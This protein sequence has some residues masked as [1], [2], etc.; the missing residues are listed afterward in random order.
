M[1][2]ARQ[3]VTSCQIQKYENDKK[4]IEPLP[5]RSGACNADINGNYWW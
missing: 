2:L 4:T 1:P 3:W 5:N